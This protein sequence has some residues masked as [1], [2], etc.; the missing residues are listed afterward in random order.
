MKKII[1]G[2]LLLLIFTGILY[3]EKKPLLTSQYPFYLVDEWTVQVKNYHNQSSGVK[4]GKS[5]ISLNDAENN[6]LNECK[7]DK[8][9]NANKPD[10]CLIYS[11]KETYQHS[12]RYFMGAKAPEPT[13]SNEWYGSVLNYESK[14]E[15]QRKEQQSI[16]EKKNK[17]QQKAINLEKDFGR[18]CSKYLKGSEQYS[19]C[20]LENDKTAKEIESKK[21]FA[22][23]QQ[24]SKKIEIENTK[25]KIIEDKQ[26]D[27]SIKLA[28]MNPDDRRAYNCTEKFGFRKGSDKFKDCIFELYKVESELEKLE[29]QKKVAQA[30]L[31]AAKVKEAAAR[32]EQD[33]TTALLQRQTLAQEMSATAAL[34]QARIADFESNQRLFDT[35][36][37][38]LRG[39][40]RVDG[41]YRAPARAPMNCQYHAKM[42]SCF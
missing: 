6:A 40:R 1:S 10:G 33:R 18:K 26:K 35:G 37:E 12:W 4:I 20:L 2:F 23:Q 28:K 9:F 7:Q 21:L 14:I 5:N 36:M 16:I 41:S 22:K 17:E 19:N 39:E 27:E 25:R 29:L 8:I 30:N 13:E 42:L 11:K 24:E 34:Q 38:M 32:S 31:E 3:A 15:N